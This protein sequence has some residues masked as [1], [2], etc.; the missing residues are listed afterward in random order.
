MAGVDEND[1]E[2]DG[3]DGVNDTNITDGGGWPDGE[4]TEDTEDG[5]PGKFVGRRLDLWEVPKRVM[6]ERVSEL[7][8]WEVWLEGEEEHDDAGEEHRQGL[9]LAHFAAQPKP[10]WSVSRFVS[11]LSRVMTHPSTEGT[12]L[13]PQRVPTLT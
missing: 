5:T 3:S 10:F 4:D 1:G 11:C 13:I 7:E 2:N 12:Q 8:L 9:T 6:Y